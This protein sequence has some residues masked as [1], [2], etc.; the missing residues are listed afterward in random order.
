VQSQ[1]Q[2]LQEW[3]RRISKE[4]GESANTAMKTDRFRAIQ[5]R[6]QDEQA[7]ARKVR[8]DV[9]LR[10]N[11]L[12]DPFEKGF[13]LG[14][15]YSA[16]GDFR[17]STDRYGDA[18]RVGDLAIAQGRATK[19]FLPVLGSVYGEIYRNAILLKNRKDADVIRNQGSQRFTNP[20]TKA[21]EEWWTQMAASLAN[22]SETVLPQEERKLALLREQVR[23]NPED[24]AKIWALA[25]T[26]SDG[27]FNL[28]EARG[29]YSWLL[30][31]HPEFPQVQNGTCQYKL[32]E[33][34]WAAREV[35]EAIKGYRNIEQMHK[36]HPRMAD[37][38]AAGVK[39]RLDECYKLSIKM[40]YN[41]AKAK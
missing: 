2:M 41:G 1:Q 38:G 34:H 27:V 21:E 4:A 3:E 16:A 9:V 35:R 6:L 11:R 13:H 5:T 25:L 28:S 32:A 31:N 14:S 15:V 33:I 17:A 29:Y 30:E 36:D 37:G 18:R 7:S 40:G 10:L 12:E 20:D 23:L 26:C 19:E 39:R 24:P 8:D 22:W